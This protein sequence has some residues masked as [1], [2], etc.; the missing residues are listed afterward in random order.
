M[1]LVKT[2]KPKKEFTEFQ[3][4]RLA[5]SGYWARNYGPKNSEIQY[6]GNNSVE[7][8]RNPESRTTT[9][10]TTLL[11]TCALTNKESLSSKEYMYYNTYEELIVDFSWVIEKA[12][13]EI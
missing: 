4:N 2:M 13:N 12:P 7:Y 3:K 5:K 1:I 9:N 6:I 8:I 10:W 11:W